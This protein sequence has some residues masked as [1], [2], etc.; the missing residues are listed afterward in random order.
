VFNGLGNLGNL[1]S[2]VK[3]ARQIGGQMGQIADEMKKRRVSGSAGGGMIEIEVNGLMEAIRCRID[4]QLI[5][6]NDRELIE[7]LVVAAFN[8]AAAKSK[9]MHADAMRELTG[10]L[11]LPAGISEALAKFSGTDAGTAENG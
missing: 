3:Q 7:D 11:P 1:A 9:Q 4:P 8:Q 5:A 6:Q 2:L 10:G